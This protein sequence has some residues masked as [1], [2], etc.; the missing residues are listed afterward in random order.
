MRACAP[1]RDEAAFDV[2]YGGVPADESPRE[3][4][5]PEQKHQA[6][7]AVLDRYRC[8]SDVLA[9]FLFG[10]FARGTS[11][12]DSDI[13][14]LVITR[15]P[16]WKE[17][18]RHDGVEFEVVRNDVSGTIAFWREHQAECTEFWRDARPL[19]DREGTVALLSL[20]A[21]EIRPRTAR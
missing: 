7:D 13:D 11:R 8:D 18:F 3:P 21:D 17:V 19:W 20:A 6:L 15:S 9:V 12:P 14:L 10:S 4:R 1:W 5:T 2:L 16:F